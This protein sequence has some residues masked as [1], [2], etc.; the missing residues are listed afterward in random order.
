MM[1]DPRS[2]RKHTKTLG[3]VVLVAALTAAA[4]G[5]GFRILGN[6]GTRENIR[7]D[8]GGTFPF[9]GATSESDIGTAETEL[10]QHILRP[11]TCAASDSSLA[12]IQINAATGQSYLSH[13][14]SPP[15]TQCP[16]I[17]DQGSVQIMEFNADD[18]DP[19]ATPSPSPPPDPVLQAQMQ[20]RATAMGPI[21]QVETVDGVPAI[22]LQG[23]YQGDCS[24]S[25]QPG[26]EG[27]APAQANGPAVLMQIGNTMVQVIGPANW[28]ESEVVAV[29]NTVQ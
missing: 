11:E 9:E 24:A 4:V 13:S 22:V 17:T 12:Q 10:G 2:L 6:G 23:N 28:T 29:A 3:T 26:R 20:A 5:G 25:P 21:A 1:K 8:P 16:G 18:A 7:L 19:M 27:C 15:P 14:A